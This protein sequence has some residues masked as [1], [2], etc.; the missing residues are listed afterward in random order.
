M[1]SQEILFVSSHMTKYYTLLYLSVSSRVVIGQFGGRISLYGP[2]KSK[3]VR[4][5]HVRLTSEI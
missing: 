4:F 1:L 2:L 3:A 5:P